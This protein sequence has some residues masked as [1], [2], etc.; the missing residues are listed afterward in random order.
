MPYFYWTVMMIIVVA[1]SVVVPRSNP[2]PMVLGA[3]VPTGTEKLIDPTKFSV[4]VIVKDAGS[5]VGTVFN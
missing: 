1:G 5:G 4:K 3:V 2:K